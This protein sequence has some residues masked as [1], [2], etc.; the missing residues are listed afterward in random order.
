VGAELFAF[1]YAEF[2][3]ASLSGSPLPAGKAGISESIYI[4]M[5]RDPETSSGRQNRVSAKI[6]I[7]VNQIFV[8][9][10]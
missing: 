2:I 3:S 9:T 7:T 1:C 10:F 4:N 6:L 8:S 5:L